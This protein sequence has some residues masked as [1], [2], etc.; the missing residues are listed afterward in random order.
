MKRVFGCSAFLAASL[1]LIAQGADDISP[2]DLFAQLDKNGDG[3]LVA[4][5]IPEGQFPFFE[6]LIRAGDVNQDQAISLVELTAILQKRD[7]SP[8]GNGA[9]NDAAQATPMPAQPQSPA[10]NLPSS[11]VVARP[12]ADETFRRLDRNGDGKLELDELTERGRARLEPLFVLLE[13]KAITIEQF[14]EFGIGGGRVRSADQGPQL[15]AAAGTLSTGHRVE[16]GGPAFLKLLDTD[17]NGKLSGVELREAPG[18]I[19]KM[20]ADGDGELSVHELLLTPRK[21]IPVSE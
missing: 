6:R 19:A 7:V 20:D 15:E 9:K 10:V 8:A 12:T 1:C 21:T 11:K 4:D 5:E 3:K 17:Q 18:L 14:R 13:T 2:A 16:L